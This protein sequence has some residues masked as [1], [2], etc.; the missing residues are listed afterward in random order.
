MAVENL[1]RHKSP[2]TDQILAELIKAGGRKIRCEI[3]ELINSIWNKEEL[4]EDWKG[5]IIV[6]IYKGDKTDCNIYRDISLLSTTLNILFNILPSRLI[7]YAQEIIGDQ[8]CGFQRNSSTTDHI[9]FIRQ[10][11][12]KKNG[13]TMKQCISYL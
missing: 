11:I 3:H 2:G 10:I 1:K 6:P 4:P 12:E 8:Q 5:S 9:F 13:S 7:P